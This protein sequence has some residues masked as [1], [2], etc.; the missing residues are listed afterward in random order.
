LLFGSR[1]SRRTR[2]RA[3]LC[4]TV[5]RPRRGAG[6]AGGRARA[7]GLGRWFAGARHRRA[8]HWQDPI[9]ERAR[10]DCFSAGPARCHGSLLG[11]GR[12][13]AL[14]ALDSGHPLG[15][16]RS[17]GARG[18]RLDGRPAVSADHAHA[19]GRAVSLIRRGGPLPGSG[20]FGAPGPRR[21]GRPARGGRVIAVAAALPG[22][23]ARRGQ[24]PARGLL[25]GGRQART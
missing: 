16:R 20:R 2:R 10:V 1:S 5:R 4:A 22:R 23:R 12:R 24:D 3:S 17:R 19:R 15:G 8:G 6:G 14:L 25:P 13:T 7:G 21:V 9:D 18:V 11:G